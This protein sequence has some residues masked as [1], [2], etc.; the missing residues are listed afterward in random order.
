MDTLVEALAILPRNAHRANLNAPSHA[1][2]LGMHISSF[3]HSPIPHSCSNFHHISL[4]LQFVNLLIRCGRKCD[5]PC[6]SCAQP[7]VWKCEHNGACPLPCGSP[8]IRLPCNKQC[9]KKLTCGH[10]CPSICGEICPAPSIACQVC[11]APA[12]RSAIVDF[13]DILL[14]ISRF[15]FF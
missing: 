13:I 6:P 2:T 10:Q 5:L 4:S 9:S 14:C 8:C 1:R 3:L 15:A 11:A 12:S 7:C